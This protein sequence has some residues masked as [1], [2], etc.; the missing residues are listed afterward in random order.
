MFLDL[1]LVP[2]EVQ[3]AVVMDALQLSV[4]PLKV[5]EDPKSGLAFAWFYGGVPRIG[6]HQYSRIG[7]LHHC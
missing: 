2:E 5:N 1:Y 3:D 4:T 7:F 6:L